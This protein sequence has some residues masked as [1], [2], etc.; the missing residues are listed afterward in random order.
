[1]IS[2]INF[3]QCIQIFNIFFKTDAYFDIFMLGSFLGSVNLSL[4]SFWALFGAILGALFSSDLATLLTVV[5][6]VGF[7]D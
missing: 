2:V 4:G 7:G 5:Q 1:M 6:W 3:C